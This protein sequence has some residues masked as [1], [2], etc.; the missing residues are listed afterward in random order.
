MSSEKRHSLPPRSIL[1]QKSNYDEEDRT[2]DTLQIT[3]QIQFPTHGLTKEQLL[4]GN[5]TTSRINTTQLHSKLN[6][7]VSFAPDVTLHKFDFV[8][9]LPTKIREPRRK[10]MLNAFESNGNEND[11]MEFTNPVTTAFKKATDEINKSPSYEPIF[12]KEVSMEITQLFTKHSAKPDVEN[13][14]SSIVKQNDEQSLELTDV[15]TVGHP[16]EFNE[17][18]V[19]NESMEMTGTLESEKDDDHAEPQMI[20]ESMEIT[21]QQILNE[22][23]DSFPLQQEERNT[24]P[25]Q[26]E[27]INSDLMHLTDLG[28]A[29]MDGEYRMKDQEESTMQMTNIF[30][31]ELN[32]KASYGGDTMDFTKVA[33]PQAMG[34]FP[35]SQVVTSTQEVQR[36]DSNDILLKVSSSKRRKL[37][38]GSYISPKK[39][40]EVHE[41]LSDAERLS[42]IPLPAEY[43][44][45]KNVKS[46]SIMVLSPE[47][48]SRD[49]FE[50]SSYKEFQVLS[51]E[52]AIEPISLE[53]F[54]DATGV[55]FLIDLQIIEKIE[56]IEFRYTEDITKVSTAQIYNA[57][58]LQIPILEIYSFIVKEL[59]RRIHDS[60]E[61]FHEV[62]EQISNNSPPLL[63]RSYFESSDEVK[64]L[65]NEQIVLIKSFARMEAKKV[66]LEW[67]CQHL[68]GIKSV[69]EENL[70]LVQTEYAGV[71]KHLN[72]I[73]DIKDRVK[74]IE[75]TLMREL[76]TLKN[77]GPVVRHGSSIAERMKIEK[78]KRELSDNMVKLNGLEDLEKQR[79]IIRENKSKLH[80]QIAAVKKEIDSLKALL[81]RKKIHSSYD[82]KKLQNMFSQI[83]LFTGINFVKLVGSE[84]HLSLKANKVNIGF[85]LLKTNNPQAVSITLNATSSFEENIFKYITKKLKQ[86][87]TNAFSLILDLQ[88][89]LY[90]IE[91]LSA[92][93]QRLQY[94]FPS[95]IL[96]RND[97][98][99]TIKITDFEASSNSKVIYYIN[100][101]DFISVINSPNSKKISAQAQILYGDDLTQALLEQHINA[102]TR[103]LLPW[104]K[105]VQIFL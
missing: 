15:Q 17:L 91:K 59:Y 44:P 45:D 78:L 14:E 103:K 51:K 61:L 3:S 13:D 104:F 48:G 46:S 71:V 66:W 28:P 5:N 80:S 69:L 52:E 88:A 92:E 54:L 25:I 43:S 72:E 58:Y 63:F 68:K 16:K 40:S 37:A 27:T 70:S 39:T 87:S 95:K 33:R 10:S 102:R 2:S 38:D 31:P 47:K 22:A 65:M 101:S 83:Q 12:D 100:V 30:E 23:Q 18:H 98:D 76:Q 67:R 81:N 99:L 19:I 57:L 9:E 41:E 8:P 49:T 26:D 85:D 73:N 64:K 77:G 11:T 56:K 6:R 50:E 79:T 86:K 105:H 74:T 21:G 53:S 90:L 29:L 75:Q 60:Q 20:E 89:E 35:S 1:K 82:V 55:S 93:F 42:P 4:G 94:V 97:H 96:T 62:Q 32:E 34:N 84:L 36:S 7:R 24:P